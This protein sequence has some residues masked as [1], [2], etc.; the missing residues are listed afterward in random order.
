M[1]AGV[2]DQA[3]SAKTFAGELAKAVVRIRIEAQL[4]SQRFDVQRPAFGV[5]AVAVKPAKFRQTGHGTRDRALKDVARYGFVQDEG[6]FVVANLL[7]WL[8]GIQVEPAGRA[9]VGR[10]SLGVRGGCSFAVRRNWAD[11]IKKNRDAF[12]KNRQLRFDNFG[13]IARI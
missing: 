10:R 3:D 1:N 6:L 7:F 11:A 2:D 5:R 4:P 12:E 9:A 13:D 8:I